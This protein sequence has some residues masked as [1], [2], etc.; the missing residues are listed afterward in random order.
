MSCSATVLLSS[1]QMYFQRICVCISSDHVRSEHISAYRACLDWLGRASRRRC[2]SS[3]Q[4]YR[5][6]S[7]RRMPALTRSSLFSCLLVCGLS[8]GSS[9]TRAKIF[10]IPVLEERQVRRGHV[11]YRYY[12]YSDLHHPS[13]YYLAAQGSRLH[14]AI[15]M[16]AWYSEVCFH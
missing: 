5:R 10:D 9:S 2:S 14:T 11:I 16:H 7:Q 6:A 8:R 12:I 13:D 4:A 15:Y 3:L 1:D